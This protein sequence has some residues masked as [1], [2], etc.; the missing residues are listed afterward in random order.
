MMSDSQDDFIDTPVFAEDLNPFD[1]PVVE[2]NEA[3]DSSS[4]AEFAATPYRAPGPGLP[5]SFGWIFLF[6]TLQFGAMIVV[7]VTAILLTANANGGEIG[8]NLEAWLDSLSP[9]K[10]LFVFTSPA[11]FALFLLIPFGLLRL[12]PR[13]ISRLNL[14]LPSFGQ[15]IMVTSVVIPLAIVGSAVMAALNPIW[16]EFSAPYPLF[17]MLNDMDAN[18]ILGQ[19]GAASLPVALFFIA[20]VPGIGE[21]FLF[22]GII[23][24]G[25]VARWGLVAGIGLTSLLFASVHMYPPHVLAI[26][27][28]GIALHWTY[29]MTKSFWAP[30]LFHFLNN[31]LATLQIQSDQVDE[32]PTHW[33]ILLIAAAYCAWYMYWL[34]Q[35]RTVHLTDAGEYVAPGNEVELPLGIEVQRKSQTYL[36]PVLVAIVMLGAEILLLLSL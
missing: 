36:T 14:N 8:F 1:A 18:A 17:R 10:K 26:V 11:F 35:M 31:A 16:L 13:P 12:A 27:P 9:T 4:G 25:L 34:T 24:R 2:G 7:L 21:E 6:F 29:L 15:T 32:E 22:R 33:A 3:E 30:V 19:F 5:E 20:V 28:M 23:G